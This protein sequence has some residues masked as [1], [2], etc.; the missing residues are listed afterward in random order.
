MAKGRL[1]YK[2]ILVYNQDSKVIPVS[3]Y[4]IIEEQRN[5][6]TTYNASPPRSESV[7][8]ENKVL[9]FRDTVLQRSKVIVPGFSAI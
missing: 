7:C 3:T 5:F 8:K 2:E 6:F 1:Y 9:L 4:L